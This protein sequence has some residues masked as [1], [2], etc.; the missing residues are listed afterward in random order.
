MATI[1]SDQID[2]KNKISAK[3][4]PRII[5]IW[6]WSSALVI[7]GSLITVLLNSTLFDRDNSEVVL[8]SL[9][10]G[11]GEANQQQAKEVLHGFEE[12]VWEFHIY[13]GYALAALLALR[14]LAEFMQPKEKRVYGKL[15]KAYHTYYLKHKERRLARHEL[16][17]KALYSLFYLLLMVMV[18]TGLSIAFKKEIGIPK[19]ISHQFKEIHGFVMYLILGFIGLHVLGVI[20][21]ENEEGKGI[22]SDM[23]NGGEE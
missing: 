18:I 7:T 8:Q 9:V 13:F 1:N 16:F 2:I 3:K 4:N 14:V 6:H 20:L 23:I 17:T 21:A 11:G 19:N 12:Q 10:S 15:K 22:V 5:R